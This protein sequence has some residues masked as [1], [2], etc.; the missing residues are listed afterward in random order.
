MEHAPKPKQLTPEEIQDL[1]KRRDLLIKE[2]KRIEESKRRG[3]GEN[4]G[5]RGATSTPREE[6]KSEAEGGTT[7]TETRLYEIKTRLAEIERRKREILGDDEKIDYSELGKNVGGDLEEL[8]RELSAKILDRTNTNKLRWKKRGELEKEAQEIED[9]IR[10]KTKIEEDKK[11][12]PFKYFL[13]DKIERENGNAFPLIFSKYID[14]LSVT[15]L[16]KVLGENGLRKIDFFHQKKIQ[17]G[18]ME[19]TQNCWRLEHPSDVPDGTKYEDIKKSTGEF[20]IRRPN[21]ITHAVEQG[22][23]NGHYVLMAA[24]QKYQ[25]EQKRLFEEIF[26]KIE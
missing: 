7:S 6:T 10:E 20:F 12:N 16:N 11:R 4:S 15:D 25:D 3:G 22:Y 24:A 9:R 26:G 5:E 1:K 19:F 18:V 13:V 8:K 17:N 14:D 21:G 23:H 2:K